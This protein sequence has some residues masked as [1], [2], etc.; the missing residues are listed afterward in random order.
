MLIVAAQLPPQKRHC[1]SINTE[2]TSCFV[3][4]N[5][6]QSALMVMRLKQTIEVNVAHLA[7]GSK[8]NMSGCST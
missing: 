3:S 6:D 7:T 4:I 1:G 2:Y 5:A 8:N